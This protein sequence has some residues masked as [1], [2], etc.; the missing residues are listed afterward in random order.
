MEE[1]EWKKRWE[2]LCTAR[3]V[4]AREGGPQRTATMP[5]GEQVRFGFHSAV[6]EHYGRK[7]GQFE[8]TSTTI[9]Y[10]VAAAVG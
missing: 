3:V 6:A 10:V 8:P 5:A 7:P 1:S 2:T 4:V 9:D